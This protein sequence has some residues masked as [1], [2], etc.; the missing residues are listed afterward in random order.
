MHTQ[1][2][3]RRLTGLGIQTEGSDELLERAYA[4]SSEPLIECYVINPLHN[5]ISMW[6]CGDSPLFRAL[7]DDGQSLYGDWKGR[8]G[9]EPKRSWRYLGYRYQVG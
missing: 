4:V 7:D 1:V 6:F 8:K 3:V 9:R 2:Y 5:V